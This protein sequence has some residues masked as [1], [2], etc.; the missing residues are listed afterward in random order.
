MRRRL[1]AALDSAA[2][3]FY[4]SPIRWGNGNDL[5]RADIVSADMSR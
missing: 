4:A 5:V 2:A 1:G 3:G